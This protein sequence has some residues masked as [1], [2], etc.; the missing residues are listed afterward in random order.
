[1]GNRSYLGALIASALA[2]AVPIN[3]HLMREPTSVLSSDERDRNRQKN[4]RRH[5][6]QRRARRSRRIHGG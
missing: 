3:A 6:A 4:R 5:A 2:G 1:M